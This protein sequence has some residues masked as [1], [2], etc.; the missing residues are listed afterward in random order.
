MWAIKDLSAIAT[1]VVGG[2]GGHL[3]KYQQCASMSKP[4]PWHHYIMSPIFV[5]DAFW[6]RMRWAPACQ[7]AA[8]V[9]DFSSAFKVV[10]LVPKGRVGV[11]GGNSPEWM[12]AMQVSAPRSQRRYQNKSVNVV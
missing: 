10:G 6:R 3:M 7:V 5:D 4:C 11:F 12:I 2:V 8:K 9:A 1:I